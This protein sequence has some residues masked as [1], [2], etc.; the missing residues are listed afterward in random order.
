MID[1]LFTTAAPL[2][3]AALGAFFTDL[4]GT[5]GIFIEGFM[6]LGSFCSWIIAGKT[7]SVFGGSLLS[8]IIMASAGWTLA[9]F[10]RRTGA[11][12]FIAALAL[13]LAAG[14]ITASLSTAWFGTKGVL[15]NP[16]PIVYEPVRFS[17]VENLPLLGPVLSGHLPYVYL[18]W[19]CTIAASVIVGRTTL[20]L[21]LKAAGR[22][23]EA[24]LERGIRTGL[25]R[26]GAWA[27]AA[28]LAAL[29]GAALTFRVGA[30]TPGG[31]AGRGW[32]ALA[33]VYLGFR[34]V[35][36]T[37]AAALLFAA[38]ELAGLGIQGLGAFPAT[39]LLGF[40][41]AVAL[42]LYTV[43]SSISKNRKDFSP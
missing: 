3:L 19:I 12:P 29:A 10:V 17:F 8:G 26:E 40:P 25:Y 14:G 16:G 31:S 33:A 23:P 18:S 11:N 2:L 32:I 4:A 37:A 24:A 20:G 21:R 6:T 9:R 13:N 22:S 1:S 15:R 5:L 36:G 28:F 35:W 41:P 39:V 7:G 42:G 34:T 30:Y 27:A 43:S 38:A